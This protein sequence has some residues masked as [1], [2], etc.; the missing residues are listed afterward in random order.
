MKS[1]DNL[2][3]HEYFQELRQLSNKRW[4]AYEPIH[5]AYLRNHERTEIINNE[6]EAR[7]ASGM[8]IHMS[9]RF[10][11]ACFD[12]NNDIRTKEYTDAKVQREKLVEELGVRL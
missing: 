6:H 9:C 3:V 5:Q 7:V 4:V 10:R 11:D 2:N 1:F 12:V 8:D